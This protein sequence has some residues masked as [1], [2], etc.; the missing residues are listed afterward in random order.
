MQLQIQ[1]KAFTTDSIVSICIYRGL[2]VIFNYVWMELN[3]SD[4]VPLKC[5]LQSIS[6]FYVFIWTLPSSTHSTVIIQRLY[7]Y[8]IQCWLYINELKLC[9][10]SQKPFTLRTRIHI[11]WWKPSVNSAIYLHASRCLSFAFIGIR[12]I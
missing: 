6:Q 1:A 8:Q 2:Y 5:F 10:G 12:R 11:I 3:T 4:N 9:L 7:V